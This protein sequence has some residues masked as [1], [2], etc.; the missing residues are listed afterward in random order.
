MTLV[1]FQLEAWVEKFSK[2]TGYVLINTRTEQ[3][4]FED[5]SIQDLFVSTF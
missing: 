2:A 3:I 1:A 4:C 5:F